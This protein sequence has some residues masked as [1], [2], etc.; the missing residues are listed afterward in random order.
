LIGCSGSGKTVSI[1]KILATYPQV[2]HHEKY[3]TTQIVFLKID[4]PF[5]GSLKSLCHNFFRAIDK[6]LHEN[7]SDRY[8]KKR[9][10]VETL[11]ALMAQVANLHAIGML[12]IDE[13]QHLSARKSG[14]AEAMLN[15]FVTLVNTISIPV[16]MVGT[17]KARPIFELDLRSA[18]RASGFGSVLWEPLPKP[19]FNEQLD[20]SEWGRFTN[21]LWKRQWLKKSNLTLSS[22]ISETWFDLSQ[23]IIDIVIKLYVLSQIRAVVTGIERIT[24]KLMRKVYEDELKPIHPM[25]D[26]LR[27]GIA[28]RIAKYSDL[29]IPYIDKRVLELTKVVQEEIERYSAEPSFGDNSKAIRLHRMLVEM[30][31]DSNLLAPLV[32]KVFQENPTVGLKD[33]IPIIIEWYS[34]VEQNNQKDSGKSVKMIPEKDWHTLDSDDLRFAFS[35]AD[36]SDELLDLLEKQGLIFNAEEWIDSYG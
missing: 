22:E 32:E 28:D 24:P 19:L 9:H 16:M 34:A 18:R 23:G 35:Q 7:Y 10:S 15:F 17:P 20:T 25:I 27:S 29:T 2:I 21:Q 4:C 36:D 6:V 33:L 12:V 1:N 8:L 3:N 11:I 26:A 13:I 14:G 5:D 30:G 31:Y